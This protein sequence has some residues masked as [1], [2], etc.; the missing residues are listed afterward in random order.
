MASLL[1]WMLAALSLAYWALRIAGV[2]GS[3]SSA[4]AVVRAP[5]APEP[6]AIAALLGAAPAAS[7]QPVAPSLASRFNLTG[8][9]AGASGAG[10]ALISVDGKPPKPYRVGAAVEEGLLL[11][12]VQGRR[13]L[14]GPA[15]KGPAALTL[16]LP[17][18]PR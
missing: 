9:V 3:D 15:P 6:A 8:V 1:L 16:E 11:Q 13:A 17:A 14:L 5:A 4:P 12:A 18:P 10:A 2:G 7:A